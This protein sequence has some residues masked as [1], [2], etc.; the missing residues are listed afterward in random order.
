MTATKSHLTLQAE[1]GLTQ[2]L[3]S[4]AQEAFF[5]LLLTHERLTGE[6]AHLFARHGLSMSQYNVLRILRGAQPDGLPAQQIVTRM[7]T[8][9]PDVTRLVD[10][11]VEAGLTE[12]RRCS[13]DRRVVWVRLTPAGEALLDTLDAPV[14]GLHDRQWGDLDPHEIEQLSTLL[15]KARRRD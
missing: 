11:L 8:R 2:P 9:D 10:R 7:V 13:A 14:R 6:F 5:N 1:L 12:R 15:W 3:E 4:T